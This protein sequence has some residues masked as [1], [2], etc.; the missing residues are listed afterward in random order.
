VIHSHGYGGS[1]LTSLS[2]DEGDGEFI[3]D[4]PAKAAFLARDN[5]AIVVSY[6]QRG[7][8]DS[9]GRVQLMDPQKE[10]RDFINLLDRIDR[11]FEDFILRS[12]DDRSPA[13]APSA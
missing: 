7:F 8:G 9:G 11:E 12:A 3:R 1:R 13:S 10:G 4:A 2:P 5:G 6:D